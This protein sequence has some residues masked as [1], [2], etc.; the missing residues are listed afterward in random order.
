MAVL[1]VHSTAAMALLL[2][3][4]VQF[5]LSPVSCSSSH[6]LSSASSSSAGE[7]YYCDWCPRHATASLLPPA[8][9]ADIADGGACGYGAMAAELV[10]GGGHVAAAAASAEFFRGGAGCGACYQLRC[11][12]PR[13]CGGD[14]VKVV[15]VT[16]AARTRETNRTG[17]QL[18]REAFAAMA[19]HGMADHLAAMDNVQIDFRRV[20]CEYRKNLAVR[21]EE[22]SRNPSHLA[23]RFLFQGGQTDIAGVEVAEAGATPQSWRPMARRRRRGNEQQ[24]TQR[25]GVW[26]TART[27][28]GPLQLRL[29]VTAGLGGKWLRAGD[30]GGAAA[31]ALPA[32][33]RPGGVYD[34]GLRVADV[35]LHTCARSC[36]AAAA[37]EELR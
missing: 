16:D 2:L 1:F 25:P 34:T 27:P 5:L 23:V 20:P 9:A 7:R 11:R 15:V 10:S 31:A 35:A 30:G 6:S 32:D 36:A 18:P 22:G 4:T 33:W 29:V 3:F 21:V 8:A 37:D 28:P 12:D 24:P 13:V 14:G 26:R 17:F 19:R